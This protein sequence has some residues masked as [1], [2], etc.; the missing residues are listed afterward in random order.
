MATAKQK[1]AAL[2]GVTTA[3]AEVEEAMV[4]LSAAQD[5]MTHA[6]NAAADAGA[7]IIE[8]RAAEAAART[9]R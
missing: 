5:R 1:E 6:V 2:A 9:S 4:A 7:N 3:A 8:L